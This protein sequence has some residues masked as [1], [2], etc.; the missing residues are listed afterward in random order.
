MT[1]HRTFARRA[2]FVVAACLTMALLA[3]TPSHAAAKIQHLISPGGIE[4]WFVQDATVPLIAMEY[5]FGGGATQ[6]PADKAGLGNMVANL[7]DEGSGDLD[8][9]TF[10][11]RL[12]R[13]AI[14][15]SFNSTRD[16]FRGSLRMLKE[17]KDEAFDL[18]QLGAQH[19]GVVEVVIPVLL[20]GEGLKNH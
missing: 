7:L 16:Y 19:V 20:V 17:N 1:C 6:D 2:A 12:D 14:E 13:R 11:E 10:H 8:S 5:A 18:L 15:L 3:P 9:K 4:A